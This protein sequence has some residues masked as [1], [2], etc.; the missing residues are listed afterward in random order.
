MDT[1]VNM[2]VTQYPVGGGTGSSG[3]GRNIE[4]RF[5]PVPYPDL[6]IR[7]SKFT[8]GW[9]NVYIE[10]KTD[11]SGSVTRMDVLRPETNG[12]LEKQ[13][14]D[15]VKREIGKWTF[16]AEETEIHVDVRF[17]VE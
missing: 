8:A 5:R 16:N 14:V 7:K 17:Y 10:L 13:F 3:Q 12:A 9:W 4:H 11:A 15:Q 6:K 1:R 2:V